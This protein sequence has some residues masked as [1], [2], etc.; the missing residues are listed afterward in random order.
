M[1]TN[2]EFG[3]RI[4]DGVLEVGCHYKG[5]TRLKT[6]EITEKSMKPLI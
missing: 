3:G 4:A 2:V 5:R 6:L 1:Q